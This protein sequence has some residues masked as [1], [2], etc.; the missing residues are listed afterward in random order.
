MSDT[1]GSAY[2]VIEYEYFELPSN[3]SRDEILNVINAQG[4]EGWQ[5]VGFS[6][7]GGFHRVLMARENP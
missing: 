2:P 7:T 3:A 4:A 6:S 1:L 5:V